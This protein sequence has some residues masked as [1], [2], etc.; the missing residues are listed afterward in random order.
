MVEKIA[1]GKVARVLGEF[2]L[3]LNRGTAHGV[4]LG[5]RVKVANVV[6]VRDP[7]SGESLGSI[8]VTK[9]KLEVSEVTDKLCVARVTDRASQD[10]TSRGLGPLKRIVEHEFDENWRSVFVDVGDVA[11]VER[12]PTLE[13][14]F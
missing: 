8:R 2:E 4:K 11:T 14:P 10:D 7:D 5:D 13:V 3:A 6:E 9:L 12:A 1:D